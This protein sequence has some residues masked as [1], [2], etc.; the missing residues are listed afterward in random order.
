[1]W[2]SLRFNIFFF[3]FT[4]TLA[5][6]SMVLMVLPRYF[7]VRMFRFWAIVVRW[8]LRVFADIHIE[9]RHEEILRDV[10]A[11]GPVIVASKHQSLLET[12]MLNL[13]LPDPAIVMKKELLYIPFYGF[14]AWKAGMLVVDR[15]GH[16]KALR[17]LLAEAKLR[18]A[19]GRPLFIYPEGTRVW[20]GSKVEYKPG[21]AAIY[22]Q[23]NL[24]CI[25]MALN[26]G[27]CWGP[28]E[29][30]KRPGRIVIEFLEPIPPGLNRR[31]FMAMLEDRIE[32]GSNRLLAE[33]K[34]TG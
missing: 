3:G 19:E 25:P 34:G 6:V 15:E 17:K 20:P 24:T 8:G 1:M 2:R 23:L 11:K 33:S 31:Q 13:L 4:G 18:T 21:I 30:A 14:L 5:V 12:V 10:L 22:N 9:F 28:R 29:W 16:A 32:T 26:T 7:V 27:V